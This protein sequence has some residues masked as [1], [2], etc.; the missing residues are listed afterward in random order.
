MAYTGEII[1]ITTVLCWT[2]SVQFFEAA[3]KRVGAIPVN[4]IRISTALI[5][6]GIFLF[7]KTGYI[8]PLDFPARSWIF[9][10]LSGIIGFFLGDICLFKALVEI[11]PRMAM[12]IF[13]L[14]APVAALIGWTFLS[15]TYLIHQWAGMLVTL[16]GVGIVILEKKQAKTTLTRLRQR[17]VT[18]KGVLFGVGGMLGQACG[19]V[20]SKS[21]ML[22]DT[23]YLDPFAAT[24]IRAIAAFV[25][26]VIF[27]TLTRKWA[28]VAGAIKDTPALI[29]TATGA[30]IG[31]FI[32]VSLS[33]LVLHYLSTGVA[34]TFLSMTPVCIIPFSIY[35]H[36]E[37][38]SIRAFG[39]AIIA[40]AGIWLLMAA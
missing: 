36:K 28:Q 6:F 39:G 34:S 17:A 1:A 33:L 29:F 11:G 20:M 38:V 13:S 27:F 4:I 22:T 2:I 3:A 40:V 26:F 25:C 23:G 7:F 30:L 15:E 35:L 37:H 32:G 24:Q 10:S 18:L 12:L 21:G 14:S 16:T 5:L 31:P 8:V 19:Y 9:L